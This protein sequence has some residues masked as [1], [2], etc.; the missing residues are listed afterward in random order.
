METKALVYCRV[1]SDSQGQS[2][3]GLAAQREACEDFCVKHN[4]EVI[5]IVEEV[6]S[7]TID[8]RP[9]LLKAMRKARKSKAIIVVAR[10]CRLSRKVSFIS[11][12]MEEGIGFASAEFGMRVNPLLIHIYAAVY[13]DQRKY[14]A[15]RTKEALRQKKLRGEPL[16]NPAWRD[17]IDDA[18]Y[19]N[20]ARADAFALDI[21]PT[22]DAIMSTGIIT[23]QDI[24]DALNARGIKTRSR[25]RGSIY[26][27]TTVKNILIRIANLK[28]H[29]VIPE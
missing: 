13:E 16:G 11:A 12:L 22:I 14:I 20:M 4:L 15:L 28:D 8:E 24:A 21:F 23:Y 3:L 17:C 27:P 1:S 25:K 29:G 19:A 6:A 9:V 5:D 10:L 2:G 7:G 18:R 26:H